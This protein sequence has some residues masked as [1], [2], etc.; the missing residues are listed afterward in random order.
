MWIKLHFVA[1]ARVL[2]ISLSLFSFRFPQQQKKH[3]RKRINPQS[4]ILG[5]KVLTVHN[6]KFTFT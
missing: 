4:T 6:Q 2:S 5:S 1:I 3:V